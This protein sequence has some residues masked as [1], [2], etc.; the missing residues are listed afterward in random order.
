MRV[1]ILC[2]AVHCHWSTG[3]GLS[4][5]AGRLHRRSDSLNGH[6]RC[7]RMYLLV[8][9][10]LLD[11]LSTTNSSCMSSSEGGVALGQYDHTQ[12]ACSCPAPGT[13]GDVQLG[14]S[15]C[16]DRRLLLLECITEILQPSTLLCGLPAGI[17]CAHVQT[18][19]E[20]PKLHHSLHAKAIS[21]LM[22]NQVAPDTS[23]KL[24]Q[25]KRSPSSTSTMP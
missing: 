16:P 23:Q 15:L 17:I 20:T 22:R 4:A 18:G 7:Q 6:G 1:C 13:M 10:L 9:T 25:P 11:P 8:W 19:T 14:L 3:L 2:V 21:H 12:K 5:S 24:L